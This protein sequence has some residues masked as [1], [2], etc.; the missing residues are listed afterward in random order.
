MASNAYSVPPPP[1]Y[2]STPAKPVYGATESSTSREPLLGNAPRDAWAEGDLE[3]DEVD[4]GYKLGTPVNQCSQEVRHGFVR[5]VYTILFCQVLFSAI[6]GGVMS[7]DSVTDW[8]RN[9]NWLV[10]TS[11]CSLPPFLS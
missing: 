11:V 10:V 1:S 4:D 5:K 9:N 7:I 2:A 3:R 6:V 8:V